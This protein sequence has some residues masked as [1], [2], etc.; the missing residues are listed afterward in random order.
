MKDLQK[1]VADAQL[2]YEMIDKYISL[3]EE[4][5]EIALSLKGDISG[6]EKELEKAKQGGEEKE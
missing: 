1:K 2:I 5:K 3:L 4:L 6:L